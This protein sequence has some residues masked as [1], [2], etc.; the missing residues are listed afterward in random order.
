MKRPVVAAKHH[1][2]QVMVGNKLGPLTHKGW[3]LNQAVA[4]K[5]IMCE[6]LLGLYHC[7]DG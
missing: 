7:L 5:G 1:I 2:E 4:S 3:V 6:I